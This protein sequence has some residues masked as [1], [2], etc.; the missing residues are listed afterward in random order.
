[1]I[2]KKGISFYRSFSGIGFSQ[3]KCQSIRHK[4]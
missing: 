4:P 1:M 2:A 3:L